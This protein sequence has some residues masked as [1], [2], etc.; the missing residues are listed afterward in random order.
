MKYNTIKRKNELL[1]IL[2]SPLFVLVYIITFYELYSF[3]RYGRYNSNFIILIICL[4]LF[5]ALLIKLIIRMTRKT[6]YIPEEIIKKYTIEQ[7]YIKLDDYDGIEVKLDNIK[8]FNIKKKYAYITLINKDILILSL[9]DIDE[10]YKENLK[11]TLYDIRDKKI[12]SSAKKV[13]L[14]LSIII[15]IS[16]TVYYGA[17]IY[18]TS[19]NFNGKLA[20]KLYDFKNKKTV[21]FE[22]NNIYT[23]GIE[24]ILTDIKE[25]VDL[26]EKLYVSDSGLNIE[27][28]RE[29]TIELFNAFIYGD[30]EN[31]ELQ[32]Y[33][34]DYDLNKSKKI[35][36]YLNGYV[37]ADYNRDKLLEPLI[38]TMKVIPLEDTISKWKENKYGIL[39]FGKRSWELNTEGVV[40][41]DN[42]GQT[43][44]GNTMT[45]EIIGYTVSVYVPGKENSITP[46]RYNLV[47]DL[48]NINEKT[49]D[50]PDNNEKTSSSSEDKE[51]YINDSIGYRL[52]VVGAALGSRFYSLE[53][54]KDGGLSWNTLNEDPFLG[55]SGGASGIV[56]INESLGFISLSHNGGDS[57]DLYRTKDG[58]LTFEQVTIPIKEVTLEN[59]AII[60]PFDFPE[61]PYEDN[62]VLNVLVG[63]GAD[64]DYNG[65]SSVLYES[66]DGGSTWKFIKEV[67]N[68]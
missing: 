13:W 64:G 1:S 34:I 27:F 49:L 5:L 56:F 17:K 33:L 11:R 36:I 23:D 2:S 19:I 61:M 29:G 47:N 10:Y 59:G 54:T 41:I 12:K 48:S 60:E 32:S 16:F 44:E 65:N 63:Q 14:Y 58:G 4:L 37:N 8:F 35:T 52:K 21:K 51:Y 62:K 22:N 25:K 46:I 42:S 55:R 57:A 20:W 3:C 53:N 43:K 39:Y 67:K 15:L 6:I 31:G 30:N 7:D 38:N 66:K 28:N 68:N 50:K 9:E 26:P 24:G 18:E 45:S 40:Y